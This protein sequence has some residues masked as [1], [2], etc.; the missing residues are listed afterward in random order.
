MTTTAP[1][2]KPYDP[3]EHA[4]K[5][6]ADQLT[7]CDAANEEFLAILRRRD[8]LTPPTINQPDGDRT[9]AIAG[10]QREVAALYR[11]AA[12]LFGTSSIVHMAF[13]DAASYRDGEAY[14]LEQLAT[15][16]HA[17]AATGAEVRATD[18]DL[19]TVVPADVVPDNLTRKA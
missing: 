7:K 2:P 16:Q 11:S 5:L 18:D 15:M 19:G 3:R 6:G 8:E 17:K 9:D 1:D 4:A 12:N 14:A 10:L 13:H